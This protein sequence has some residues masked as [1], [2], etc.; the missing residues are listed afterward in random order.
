MSPPVLAAVAA[1]LVLAGL[2]ATVVGLVGTRRPTA[3]IA[4]TPTR[5]AALVGIGLPDRQR[6]GRRI[7]IGATVAVTVLGWLVTG[8]PMAGITAGL[9]VAGVP[10]LFG[11][12]RAEQRTIHRLEAVASWTRRLR[13]LVQTGH[14][15]ISAIVTSARTAPPTIAAEVTALAADLQTGADPQLALDRF[16]DQLDGFV[17]DEVIAALKLHASDRGQRLAELLAAVADDA[18]RQAI[19]R[20]GIAA[21]RAEPKFVTQIMTV[22][23]LV[24]LTGVF[25]DRSYSAP[26]GAPVGELVLLAAMALLVG[27]LV[28]IRR[29]SQPAPSER[30]LATAAER[31]AR[32]ST[33]AE[34]GLRHEVTR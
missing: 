33:P 22:V 6:R 9:A 7:M 16:A 1:A 25:A 5:L 21:K 3:A 20:R 23:I 11:A 28:W 15:L 31:R 10:W 17:S 4:Q 24:V 13:D 14:G 19:S 12:G 30:F 32:Q 8:W 26:Y 29:L 27:L 2:L 18:T 34:P